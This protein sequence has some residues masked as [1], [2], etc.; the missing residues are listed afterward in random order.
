MQLLRLSFQNLYGFMN[1][2][3]HFH[4]RIC[5]LVGING[6]GK[7]SVLNLINWLLTLNIEELCLI[8]FKQITLEFEHDDKV[9]ELI[10]RQKE[11][12]ITFDLTNIDE[13]VNFPTI[14]ANFDEHPKMLTKNKALRDLTR[15]K[16]KNLTPEEHEL[17]TWNF[18]V[19]VLPTPMIIGLDRT[20]YT[21]EG[22]EI[23]VQEE[24][25]NR[26][27]R[28]K[29]K[30]LSPI[31]QVKTVL[32][33]R[34]NEYRNRV[35]QFYT[36]INRKI[37]LSSFDN[38]ITD[39]SL[40]TLINSVK[41]TLTE[42]EKLQEQV[43]EFLRE[44]KVFSDQKVF[45]HQKQQVQ[46]EK[47]NIAKVDEYFSNLK[48]ILKTYEDS[49]ESY[50]LLY[51]INIT[52]FKKINDLVEEF[53]KY[54]DGTN[55]L[56]KP[57]EEFLKTINK[58]FNDSSKELYFDKKTSRIYFHILD[59]NGQKLD[60]YRD[61]EN[62]SSGEKQILILLTHIKY[63]SNL[64]LF[65]VDEPELSLHPKWQ[66]EFLDAVDKLMPKDAQLIIATHSP[67]IVGDNEEYCEVLLPYNTDDN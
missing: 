67:E 17:E 43:K 58:F 50:N 45:S 49:S 57:L 47:N 22:N 54:E 62:L 21:Q 52:Q 35:L 16:L 55:R 14:Q 44:N 65:I 7:T 40:V 34:Y 23:L 19:K 48:V 6:S 20:L 15:G 51:L 5:I 42:I 59:S 18:I 60:S 61:L 30:N 39:S 4:E 3:I 46:R 41:P 37:I 29:S 1:K 33:S 38:I 10:C 13:G 27:L 2:E 53:K 24:Y 32:T 63:N 11:S 8:E 9:Y 12:E 26:L 56:Y 25:S 31:D 64:N 28:Q 36:S 66:G